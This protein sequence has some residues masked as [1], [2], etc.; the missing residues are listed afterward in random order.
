MSFDRPDDI[1]E[2]VRRPYG[3]QSTGDGLQQLNEGSQADSSMGTDLS[4]DLPFREHIEHRPHTT[5]SPH[6]GK[7]TLKRKTSDIDLSN[8][9]KKHKKAEKEKKRKT[10]K[11]DGA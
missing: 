10:K 8:T 5:G 1:D 6:R 9:A 4:N 11:S 3:T 2:T 7:Y